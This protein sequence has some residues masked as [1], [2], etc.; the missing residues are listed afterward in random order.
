MAPPS[1]RCTWLNW[2]TREEGEVSIY[3]DH[4]Q[5]LTTF[6]LEEVLES[7]LFNDAILWHAAEPIHPAAPA[8]GAIR[9]IL[10]FDY[11]QGVASS[12]IDSYVTD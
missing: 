4:R 11:H 10:T 2:S 7:Y 1:S 6:R 5:L 3:D 12:G 8:H 9:S